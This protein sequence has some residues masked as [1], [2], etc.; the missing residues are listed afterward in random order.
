VKASGYTAK[1]QPRKRWIEE[2][3]ERQSK[4][5]H[6]VKAHKRWIEE[7]TERQSKLLHQ[8]KAHKRWIEEM[9]ERQINYCT[10]S[11][12]TKDGLKK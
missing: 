8:V 7:M 1:G 2:M 4:L 6:Q 12:H 5:L 9:T 10:R 3:T 11:K